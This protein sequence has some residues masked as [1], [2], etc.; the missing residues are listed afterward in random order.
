[1]A[2]EFK[3]CP[4][5]DERHAVQRSGKM[6]IHTTEA[7]TRCDGV[8]EELKAQRAAR[9]RLAR[10]ATQPG[11]KQMAAVK[12]AMQEQEAKEAAKRKKNRENPLYGIR[13]H[14]EPLNRGIYAV[15]G[16]RVVSGGL[17]TLG[18]GR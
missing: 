10:A 16:A 9:E 12:A 6:S 11:A 17:P 15:D 13:P 3:V 2:L 8:H 14:R 1:M 5:C 18:R 7:G 4:V